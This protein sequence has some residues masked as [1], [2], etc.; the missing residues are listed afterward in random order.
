MASKKSFK[1]LVV[2]RTTPFFA[3]VQIIYFLDCSGNNVPVMFM[4]ESVPY[5]IQELRLNSQAIITADN[6][7]DD[8]ETIYSDADNS[9]S[10][11][12]DEID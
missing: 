12:K 7:S 1:L 4:Q 11:E 10:S 5:K 2:S 9:S 8:E 6:N 3:F